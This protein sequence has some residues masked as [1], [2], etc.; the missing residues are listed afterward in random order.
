MSLRHSSSEKRSARWIVSTILGVGDYRV[1]AAERLDRVGDALAHGL[2]VA[3]VER[4][5]DRRD[6]ADGRARHV[7]GRHRAVARQQRLGERAA[8]PPG[9]AGDDDPPSR[10]RQAEHQAPSA[11]AGLLRP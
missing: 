9:R 6:V 3:K 7:A 5:G 8:D 11:A 10:R 4:R 1:A 2:R